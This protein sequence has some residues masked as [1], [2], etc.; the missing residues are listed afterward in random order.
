MTHRTSPSTFSWRRALLAL[1][2]GLALT[3]GAVIPHGPTAEHA[4][5]PVSIEFD[6]SAQHPH[7][8][9]HLEASAIEVHP[10]CPAC[11][12]QLQTASILID[13]RAALPRPV[14]QD[15]VTLSIEQVGSKPAPRL[16]PARAPPAAS[17]LSA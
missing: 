6:R 13:L 4:E 17:P 16:G 2:T 10:G 7:A 12:V 9:I 5:S 1:A 11:L 14:P 15:A 8:P 3:L